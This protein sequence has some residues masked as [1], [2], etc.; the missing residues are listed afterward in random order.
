MKLF[1][2]CPNCKE[3]FVIRS[4]A[5][6]RRDLA[7]ELGENFNEQ[8]SNCLKNIKLHVNDVRAKISIKKQILVGLIVLG[9]GMFFILMLLNQGFISSLV[10]IFPLIIYGLYQ[11]SQEKSTILFNSYRITRRKTTK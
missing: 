2:I 11:H 6:D 4:S 7:D 8:C 5:I 3:D 1:A 10:F 9:L